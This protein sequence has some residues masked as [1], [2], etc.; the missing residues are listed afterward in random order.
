MLGPA[1][2]VRN[3]QFI[4]M[5]IHMNLSL[6]VVALMLLLVSYI[7]Y[8]GTTPAISRR[9]R[10]TLTA[11]RVLSFACIV[12]LLMDP[13]Y[14]FRSDKSEPAEIVVLID[15]SASM[16][17]PAEGWAPLAG[18]TR[19]ESACDVAGRLKEA[20]ES[21]GGVFN[22]VYFSGDVL[23][24]PADSIGPDGQG[25]DIRGALAAAFKRGEG[26]N[27]AGFIVVSDGIDT[28][29]QLIR[30][31]VPPVPVYTIG[32]GD[33][34][35]PT[36]VRIKDVAYNSIVRVPSRSAID[37]IIEYSGDRSSDE[38]GTKQIHIRLSEDDKTVFEKDTLFAGPVREI[39][40]RIPVEFRE[41]GRR[42][43]ILD[44]TVQGYDAEKEN[45]RRE[46]VVEAEKA[47]VRILIVDQK[48]SW[49]LHFLTGFLRREQTF[50]FDVV[51]MIAENPVLGDGKTIHPGDFERRL[52]D[53]DALVIVSVER[54]FINVNT[55]R[56]IKRF[57]REDE[58]GILVLPGGSASLFERPS[59]WEHLSD[60]LPV[61]GDP[62]FRFNLQ[63]T[64]VRPGSHAMN[65]PVTSQ[66]FPR[67]GQT[68]WQQRSPLLGC[69]GPHTPKPRV[70]ILLE[71]VGSRAPALVYHEVDGGRVAL[72]CAGPLWRWKFLSE[73]NSVYEDLLSR[74]LDV[75][76]RGGKTER[77]VL[78]SKRN[79][80]DSGETA[81]LTAEIFNEK[82]QPVTGAPVRV[83]VSR[84]GENGEV[85]LD[86]F[87]MRREGSD[88]PRFEV[89]LPAFS[90]GHYRI[91]GQADLPGRTLSSQ[92]V[93][94]SISNV[95]VEFKR[96][97]RDR[98]NLV[99]VARQS[100][101]TYTDA[102][103]VAELGERIALEPRVTEWT[104]EIPLR[105]SV[106][107]FA[108]IL[109]LLSVEWIIRKRAGMI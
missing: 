24:T 49:E 81:V 71:T 15:R 105:T 11:L 9:L 59:A 12:F 99:S 13:R 50:D 78:K 5:A 27:L 53:Y 91:R 74:I 47:G 55:A 72:M 58:K 6:V 17:L 19:F 73:N 40:Q 60:L 97:V 33:T 43:F 52:A 103:T 93:D 94:I 22:E 37:A 79:V 96:V 21:R 41:A 18:P 65:N 4:V 25:T 39:V 86:I 95:S 7:A 44:V 16:S 30:R 28:E 76:S 85:P 62:P 68:E 34:N 23:L 54:D 100:G 69:Y 84:V 80:Y 102:R 108:I 20:V 57:V 48:P 38:G 107:L 1:H 101:G 98:S 66:L 8:R 83:E 109:V 36:D 64:S 92:P 46:I 67:L 75:L 63:Y 56:A 35:A 32:V 29:E 82:M 87:A 10:I 90:P 89:S 61:R 51:S 104:A 2:P 70:E 14:V 106:V 77:F 26:K 45:N 42:H 88:N 3:E 31:P